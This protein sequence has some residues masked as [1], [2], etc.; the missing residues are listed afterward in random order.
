M[1]HAH[2]VAFDQSV[3]GQVIFLIKPQK[4]RQSV[5]G[6]RQLVYFIQE[7]VKG[8]RRRLPKKRLLFRVRES[9]VPVYVSVAGLQQTAL[10]KSLHLV[11]EADFL[12]RNGPMTDSR[13][14]RLQER[15][16]HPSGPFG[17]HVRAAGDLSAE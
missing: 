12:V 14:P 6:F 8:S 4:V 13:Q 11:F 16:R 3:V 2:A 10:Q 7:M 1:S 17:K 5:A 9:S 15:A